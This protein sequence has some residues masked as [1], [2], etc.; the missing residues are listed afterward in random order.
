MVMSMFV[1]L[2]YTSSFSLSLSLTHTHIHSSP[3]STVV[4]GVLPGED[5]A[6]HTA[7]LTLV[8]GAVGGAL[9]LEDGVEE[10]ASVLVPGEAVDPV[11]AQLQV[12]IISQYRTFYCSVFIYVWFYFPLGFGGTSG[13]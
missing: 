2:L 12:H 10:V 1:E 11:H 7:D 13:R 8:G 9:G 5:M 4:V 6:P 3:P